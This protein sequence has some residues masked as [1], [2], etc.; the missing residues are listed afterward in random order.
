MT[1]DLQQKRIGSISTGYFKNR[2]ALSEVLP[3]LDGFE[4]RI[5]KPSESRLDLLASKVT[6]CLADRS[7]ETLGR[8]EWRLVPWVI[9]KNTGAADDEWFLNRMFS[10]IASNL[11]KSITRALVQAYIEFFNPDDGS[12]AKVGRFI[13]Q[14]ALKVETRLG[15]HWLRLHALVHFFEPAKAPKAIAE[16]VLSSDSFSAGVANAG[17]SADQI[18]GGLARKSFIQAC[19]QVANSLKVT[20]PPFDTNR[21]DILFDWATDG[22]SGFRYPGLLTNMATL[23][24]EAVMASQ[25]SL[26][27]QEGI[28]RRFVGLMDDPRV[29][30]SKWSKVSSSAFEYVMRLLVRATLD[31]FTKVIDATADARHWS[32]RKPF[33]MQYY[34]M[35]AISDAWV[36]FGPKAVS[37]ADKLE[38]HYAQLMNAT[39]KTHSALIMRIHDLIIVEWS[40]NG[41]CRFFSKK[42]GSWAP[43]LYAKKYNFQELHAR[44]DHPE[45]YMSHMER[46]QGRFA[47]YIYRKTNV[48]HPKY[49]TGWN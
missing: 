20:T 37:R 28:V 33:W 1:L 13:A 46:W 42:S 15:E 3:R 44:S 31:D 16:L 39:E 12:F 23:V 2:T 32:E 7:C 25:L 10:Y 49:G 27:S 19:F 45:G 48:R 21:V 5:T 30:Q 29:N 47:N 41:R 17:L 36:A 35:G 34:E 4:F 6:K 26:D 43:E 11:S 14:Q 9:W 22:I 24:L 8:K 18:A 40:H 38:K